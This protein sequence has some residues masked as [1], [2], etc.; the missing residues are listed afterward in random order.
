MN[1]NKE[2]VL[3]LTATSFKGEIDQEGE[4]QKTRCLCVRGK[5]IENSL[6]VEMFLCVNYDSRLFVSLHLG[7]I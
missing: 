5:G 6:Y 7:R 3:R 4:S 2:I 1:V